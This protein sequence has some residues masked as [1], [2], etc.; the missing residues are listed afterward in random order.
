VL[1]SYKISQDQLEEDD[2]KSFF[3][4][5]VGSRGGEAT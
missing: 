5:L 3:K 2:Q 1:E 4:K